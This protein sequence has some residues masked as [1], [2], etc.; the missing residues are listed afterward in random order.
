MSAN[1]GT[2]NTCSNPV[3]YAGPMRNADH[4]G[5]LYENTQGILSDSAAVIL[6][7]PAQ[8]NGTTFL[9]SFYLQNTESADPG[10]DPIT[11]TIRLVTVPEDQFIS[12]NEYNQA[13]IGLPSEDVDEFTLCPCEGIRWHCRMNPFYIKGDQ[14]L[15][16]YANRPDLIRYTIMYR[17]E[18]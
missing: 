2:K 9:D 10:N 16:A 5:V 6:R 8:C 1:N 13:Y 3:G 14:I 11:V 7:G 12:D 17:E 18:L 15:V 4:P